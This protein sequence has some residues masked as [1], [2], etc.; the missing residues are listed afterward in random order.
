MVAI[1]SGL[2]NVVMITLP[3]LLT[4]YCYS[5]GFSPSQTGFVGAALG[6]GALAGSAVTPAVTRWWGFG[7]VYIAFSLLQAALWPVLLVCHTL[8]AIAAIGA[9]AGAIDQ[10][11]SVAQYT[12]RGLSIP[13]HLSARVQGVFR[14]VI[15]AGGTAGSLLLGASDQRFGLPVVVWGGTALLSAGGVWSCLSPS[16]CHA[17]APAAPTETAAHAQTTDDLTEED[18]PNRTVQCVTTPASWGLES[19]HDRGGEIRSA[20]LR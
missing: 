4:L 20:S 14:T 1:L 3:N 11:V 2:A 5:L 7:F 12:Y 9:L 13:N 16:I 19:Q 6:V 10:I 17:P 15:Y 18:T 8:L